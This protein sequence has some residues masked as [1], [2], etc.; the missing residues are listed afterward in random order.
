MFKVNDHVVYNSTGVYKI[1]DIRNEKDI[2]NN[3]TDYYVLQPVYEKNLTIKTPVNNTKVLM[4]KII[5]KDD[6]L[7]LIAS[8]PEKETIW[9]D[10]DR[11]RSE[12]FRAAF[13]TGNS[14]EW[15]KLIKTIYLKKMEK[16]QI[17]KKLL[18]TDVEIMEK[19]EKILYEEFAIAL[20]LSPDEVVTYIMDHVS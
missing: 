18:K 1:I 16:S 10:D 7:S 12:N 17:G 5:K 20:D 13:R 19:A 11:Q 2:N 14:E 15:V 3:D 9:T 6:A 8:M 4:R